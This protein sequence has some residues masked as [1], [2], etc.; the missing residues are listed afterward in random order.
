M[1]AVDG[2][3]AERSCCRRN[4]TYLFEAAGIS[5]S[6]SFKLGWIQSGIGGIGTIASWFALTKFGRKPLILGG[7]VT[8]LAIEMWVLLS[9]R[10]RLTPKHRRLLGHSST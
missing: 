7:C 9:T 1:H 2:P 8:M 4:S 5:A 6:T 3:G 10:T